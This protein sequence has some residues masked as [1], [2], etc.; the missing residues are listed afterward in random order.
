MTIAVSVVVK[1]SR[2]LLSVL[3]LLCIGVALVG[4]AIG[5]GVVGELSA[6]V[7]LACLLCCFAAAG[8]GLVHAVKRRRNYYLDISGSGQIRLRHMAHGPVDVFKSN[9]IPHEGGML[10]VLLADS[11]LWP[12]FLMLRLQEDGGIV[13]VLPVLPD[14]LP[15][16]SFRALG[17]A[18]RWIAAH[19][20]SEIN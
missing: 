8:G 9:I 18:C 4:I 15:V 14:S 20:F 13:H 12:R 6:W 10:V 17:V 5:L 16:E 11:T 7:R 1:P 2:L 3:V 19:R